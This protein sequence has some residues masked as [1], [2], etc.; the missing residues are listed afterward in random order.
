[1][2]TTWAFIALLCTLAFAPA[3]HA[4]DAIKRIQKAVEQCTLDQHGTPPFHLKATLAPTNQRDED[5]GRTG[6]VQIWWK[7]SDQWRREV[8]SPEF[9]QVQI[10]NGSRI[11]QKNEGD[12][13]PEW[14][15]EAAEALVKPVPLSK[16]VLEQMRGGEERHQM[17]GTYLAW[18][19]PSSN[20]QVQKS[21][22]GG[23]SI[24]DDSGLLFTAGGFGWG[25]EF[26]DYA[27]FHNRMVARTM[28]VGSPEVTAKIVIL[29]DLRV[30]QAGWF[31]ASAP[32]SDEQPINTVLMN[33]LT[34]R[35]NLVAGQNISWPALKDGPL[36]GVLTTEVSIDRTGKVRE[37]GTIVSDNPGVSGA[38]REQIA[39]MRFTPFVT[40]GVPAQVLSRITL[41]FKAARPA[42][43]ETFDSARH[44]FER[45][46][47][48]GF[49]SGGAGFPY[50]LKAEF[51]ARSSAGG[52]DTGHY[53]DIWVAPDKWRR[54]ATFG[55]SHVVRSRIG[56]KLFESVEGPDAQLLLVIFQLMEPI[57]T[58]DTL[59]DSDWRI[60]SDNVAGM[61]TVRV[62]SGYESPEGKLDPEHAR[63]FWFD[64]NGN[65]VK[66][67][68]FGM[69]TLRSDF[70][71]YQ[72][73]H[74]ARR[75]DVTRDSAPVMHIR[76]L[77]IEGADDSLPKKAFELKGHEVNKQYT[78]VAR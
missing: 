43:A 59:V 48:L 29:E 65:L 20:G 42:D 61:K 46:R 18:T 25:G 7:A 19:I 1:M 26:K 28:S 69:E 9:H 71:N 35:E 77:D 40:D 45:G 38:A 54:E 39:A 78:S 37:I 12:Y 57:P 44:Y 32:G 41:A 17:G 73:V 58:M 3:S 8:R 55:A 50:A 13:F 51:Q 21:M 63:G 60:K 53:G 72:S 67:W 4:E 66:T 2:R 34:A 10:V 76:I 27:K 24:R 23:V 68:F 15:R 11:W 36:E 75:I 30:V 70:E 49:P 52:V 64:P 56:S 6:E 22:G 14:L 47:Q 31:D 5:S 16:D 33:E 74:V 62:L